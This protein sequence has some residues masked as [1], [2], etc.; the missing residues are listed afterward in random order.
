MQREKRQGLV[1]DFKWGLRFPTKWPRMGPASPTPTPGLSREI[2]GEQS[3]GIDLEPGRVRLSHAVPY[4]P[5]GAPP[6]PAPAGAQDKHKA[7]PLG[8]WSRLQGPA[9]RAGPPHQAHPGEPLGRG[10]AWL[11][12]ADEITC[13]LRQSGPAGAP[14]PKKGTA[15]PSPWFLGEWFLPVLSSRPAVQGLAWQGSVPSCA[16]CPP[17]S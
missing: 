7:R 6:A 11:S 2:G 8:A 16:E 13:S 17:E 9:M 5:H 15:Q 14:P 3:L 10:T 1:T 12:P 4:P